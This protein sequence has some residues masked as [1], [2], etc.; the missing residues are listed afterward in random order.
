LMLGDAVPLTISKMARCEKQSSTIPD[1]TMEVEREFR[2]S[3]PTPARASVVPD[4]TGSCP[5]RTDD[6]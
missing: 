3:V 6:Q 5:R 2:S 4:R 1:K